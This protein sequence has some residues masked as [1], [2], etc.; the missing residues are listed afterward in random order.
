[1]TGDPADMAARLRALL[2]SRW[3]ADEAPVLSA[4][5]GGLG[6]FWSRLHGFVAYARA[7]TRIATATGAWLDM[8]ARDFFGRRVARRVAEGDTAFRVRIRRELLR[9]RGTRAALSST[10]TDL[11]GRVP[12]IF[13]PARPADTGAWG[14][15]L[16]YNTQGGWG[17][18]SLPFQAFVTAFRPAGSGIATVAGW[19]TPPGGYGAG[20]IQYASLA[21]VQGQVTDADI[22]AAI[23]DTIPA[24]TTAWTRITF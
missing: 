18:L 14:T 13:E 4:L 12:I 8:I 9:D 2:P 11:T 21:M 1:M 15:A 6:S 19:G 5:L 7:Q 23:T 24:A 3:F 22:L 17:T 10:L 20:A 16:A